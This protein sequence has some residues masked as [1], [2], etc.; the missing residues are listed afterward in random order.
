MNKDDFNVEIRDLVFKAFV[1]K[2]PLDDIYDILCAL[3]NDISYQKMNDKI[4][5]KETDEE[6][7]R[8]LDQLNEVL[9]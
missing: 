4:R 6:K 9:Y 2:I 8:M 5:V 1:D 3:V 7:K